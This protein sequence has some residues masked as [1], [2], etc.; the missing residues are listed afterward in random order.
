MYVLPCLSSITPLL[1]RFT[2]GSQM[3]WTG[4]HITFLRAACSL[5]PLEVVDNER[6]VTLWGLIAMSQATITSFEG[7]VI[8]RFCLGLFEGTSRLRI[9]QITPLNIPS[10]GLLPG[11]ILYMSMFYRRHQMQIRATLM[12]NT[13]ALAGAFSG[14]LASA[15]LGMDGF[16]GLRGWQWLF[17]L[18][19]VSVH[20]A[21]CG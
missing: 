11:L 14:L 3:R 8:C 9:G 1:N 7:L 16:G 13:T 17:V 12:F 20:P 5:R 2:A 19:R 10:G 15:I 18:V 4:Y 21:T 6:Q